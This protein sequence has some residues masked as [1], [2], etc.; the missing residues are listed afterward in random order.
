VYL[1][2]N[3]LS[4]FSCCRLQQKRVDGYTRSIHQTTRIHSRMCLLGA[5]MTK[6]I[7]QGIKTPKNTPKVGVVR[8]FQARSKK[9]WKCYISN[10]VNQINTKFEET[11][12][13]ISLP[14][15]VVLKTG[16]Q[17]P[18]RRQP[19]FWKFKLT[20]ITQ[21][22]LHTFTQNLAQREQPTSWKQNYLQI[23][24]IWKSKMA[25]GRHVKNT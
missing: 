4:F 21:S 24:L 2:F 13:T 12:K 15:W 25:A 14:S 3:S 5:S 16:Y 1:S 7:V 22:L 6:N 10:R 17:N 8:Q 11:L 18:R 19:P 20:T 23:S 9:N